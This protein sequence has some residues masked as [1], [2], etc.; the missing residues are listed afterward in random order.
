[1]KIRTYSPSLFRDYRFILLLAILGAAALGA[2]L[3]LLDSGPNWLAGWF[4]F[5]LLILL[6]GGAIWGAWKATGG[7]AAPLKAALAAALLRLVVGVALTMLLPV[8]GYASDEVDQKGYFFSDAMIR[9]Y[10]SWELATLDEEGYGVKEAFSGQ[11]SSD[12]YGGML[13]LSAG[14]YRTLSRDEH[15]QM[16][17]LVLTAAASGCGVLFLWKAVRNWFG[18]PTARVAAWIFALYPEAVLLGGSQ[19]REPFVMTAV[20][21]TFLS[22]TE[23]QP[24]RRAW[25]GWLAGGTLIL[26]F[27]QPPMALIAWVVMAG[28]WL[29]GA[30]QRSWK[31]IGVFAAILIVLLAVVISVWANLPSLSHYN[32]LNVISTWLQNNYKF[33]AGLIQQSSGVVQMLV[34]RVGAA[35]SWLIFIGY[36]LAQPVLPALVGDPDAAAIMRVL[37]F[38][39]AAGWYALAPFLL[40]GLTQ[41]W[42]ARQRRPQLIWITLA[43]WIWILTSAYTAGGDQWDNPRYRAVLLAWEALLAAWAWNE[44]RT[45]GDGWLRR[46]LWVEVIFVLSFTEWYV[47]R[48]NFQFAH[49]G[50]V[51]VI[52]FNLGAALLILGGSWLRDRLKRRPSNS[53]RTL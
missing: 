1:M 10:Q 25:L 11:F 30:G 18:E 36:G 8:W 42:R 14:V 53:Q 4:A 49:P 51:E 23:M 50:I 43:I 39:R 9:D 44:A 40:Y 52:I 46:W 3:S 35:N 38:F 47:T 31:Q 48:Y 28:A 27:F 37:G 29:L 15:R 5:T 34:K 17:I 20:A 13:A 7:E 45:R 33:Q 12:Q 6:G 21:M 32:P 2:L 22:L 41:V 19:M 26:F 16:L 24:G